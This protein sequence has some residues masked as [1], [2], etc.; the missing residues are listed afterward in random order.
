MSLSSALF[1]FGK[2]AAAVAIAA[3][4]VI[5]GWPFSILAFL[6]VTVY[7]LFRMFK[8][9]FISG[10]FTSL[11]LMVISVCVDYFYYG[12]WTSS[13][14]NLLIY[15]VVG[16]G[17]SHLYGTEGPLFYLRNGF[18]NFNFCFILALLFIATL[19]IARKKYAPELL[20]IISPI[21]IWL[22]FM[23]LQP[24]KEERSDQN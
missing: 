21:Y 11:A 10:A 1:L 12:K 2:P 4:G 22:A 15:D 3:T 24:H 5:P 20:V 18:N 7:S 23:S 8:Y 19:P 6:P 17:E 13:V 14:L 9:A 16:G